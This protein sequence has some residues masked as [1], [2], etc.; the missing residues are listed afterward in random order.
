MEGSFHVKT[1]LMHFQVLQGEPAQV[2]QGHRN[3]N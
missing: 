3:E 1:D 2:K